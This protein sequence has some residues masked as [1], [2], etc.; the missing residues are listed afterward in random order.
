LVGT[1]GADAAFMLNNNLVGSLNCF[2]YAR[3]REM[4]IVF[5]STSRVYPYTRINDL[6][7]A[8]RETRFEC[9]DDGPG[10]SSN[11]IAVSFP[12][13]GRR[14]LYG[15]TKLASEFILQEYSCQYDLPAN[16]NRCGVVAGPWQLGKADQGVFT[17]WMAQH[18]FG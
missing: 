18:Y 1:Q 6:R 14:S 7:F 10:I 5:L 16:I 3:R 11:G 9:V 12:L 4:P 15:A 13:E 8:E 17:H 2:E